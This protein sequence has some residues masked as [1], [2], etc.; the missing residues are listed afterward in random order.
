M[1]S[2]EIYIV[3][4]DFRELFQTFFSGDGD[5]FCQMASVGLSRL[6]DSFYFSGYLRLSKL[7]SFSKAIYGLN[8]MKTAL[9]SSAL[10]S[11]DLY[12]SSCWIWY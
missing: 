9:G 10:E 1:I 2:N 7:V 3:F 8:S 6:D 12:F 4:H 11:T 5:E